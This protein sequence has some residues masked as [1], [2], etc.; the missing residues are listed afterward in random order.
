M[1]DV[2]I[3]PDQSIL[4][5]AQV[6]VG[7]WRIADLDPGTVRRMLEL[8]REVEPIVPTPLGQPADQPGPKTRRSYETYF[9]LGI[10]CPVLGVWEADDR[11][12][13]PERNSHL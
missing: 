13:Q 3:A 8:P 4:A 10:P 11:A 9:G 12:I 5:A 1:G 6:C 2:A 7:T